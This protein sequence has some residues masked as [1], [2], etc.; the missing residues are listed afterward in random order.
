[1]IINLYYDELNWANAK[2]AENDDKH[3]FLNT[4]IEACFRADAQNYEVLRPALR[5]FMGKYPA[6]EEA[7][8]VEGEI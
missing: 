6:K 7:L 8:K 4:F 1:M 5:F 2:R 3:S